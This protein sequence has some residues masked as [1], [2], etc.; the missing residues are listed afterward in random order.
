MTS[1]QTEEKSIP[2][3]YLYIIETRYKHLYTG[4]STDW[5]R[6]YQEHQH[7]P[8]KAAKALRGKGPLQ[9]KYC[10]E[11]SGHSSAL[12]AEIW[13]KKQSKATK[14]RIINADLALPF[15]HTKIDFQ[16]L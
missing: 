8:K 13:L 5:Q 7:E 4:I 3:W 16:K 12:K 9:I 10:V 1:T 11:L 14:L 15:E 6:R 2:H